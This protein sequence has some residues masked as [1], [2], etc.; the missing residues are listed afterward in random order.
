MPPNFP[1]DSCLEQPLAVTLPALD[2]VTRLGDFGHKVCSKKS[3]SHSK[4]QGSERGRLCMFMALF[5]RMWMLRSLTCAFYLFGV[6]RSRR[7]V[8]YAIRLC[9]SGRWVKT[10]TGA[11]HLRAEEQVPAS[12]CLLCFLFFL[13][14]N[15]SQCWPLFQTIKRST[16]QCMINPHARC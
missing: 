7:G 4:N 12:F 6:C 14:T 2:S 10:R 11:Q 3:N 16:L 8:L 1:V 9:L 13:S 15:D 5:G